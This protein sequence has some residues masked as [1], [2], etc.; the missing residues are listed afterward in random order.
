M[1]SSLSM[2]LSG[3]PP[4]ATNPPAS[5]K[6]PKPSRLRVANVDDSAEPPQ[7]EKATYQAKVDLPRGA[8]SNKSESQNVDL[9]G[10][11]PTPAE[12]QAHILPPPKDPPASGWSFAASAPGV[13]KTRSSRPTQDTTPGEPEAPRERTLPEVPVYPNES[14]ETASPDKKGGHD[15]QPAP[16]DASSPPVRRPAATEPP[17]RCQSSAQP[18]LTTGRAYY[19]P[20]RPQI[21]P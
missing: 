1:K 12:Q 2:P 4:A 15:R 3:E 9:L 13:T 17:S 8:N 5:K 19:I 16:N 18:P 21:I 7:R 10:V 6:T 20:H 14:R 11:A